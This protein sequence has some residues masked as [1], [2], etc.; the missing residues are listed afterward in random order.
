MGLSDYNHVQHIHDPRDSLLLERRRG[1]AIAGRLA[2]EFA[3]AVA[4]TL[5]DRR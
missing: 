4:V 2:I 1:T 3:E 5:S